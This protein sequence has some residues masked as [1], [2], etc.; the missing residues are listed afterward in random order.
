MFNLFNKTIQY[1]SKL[2]YTKLKEIF[3]STT[4]EWSEFQEISQYKEKEYFGI[5]TKNSIIIKRNVGSSF[6]PL[7]IGIIHLEENKVILQANFIL[8]E[9]GKVFIYIFAFMIFIVGIPL[10][11]FTI[12]IALISI[13]TF[14]C[15]IICVK[16]TYNKEIKQLESFL[17][18]QLHFKLVIEEEKTYT[19][20]V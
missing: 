3:E 18:L 1:E 17:I 15:S 5:L 9:L 13:L 19:Q 2:T 16:F 8:Q 4:I 11:F 7:L 20:S 12:G 14:L 10:L 6:I